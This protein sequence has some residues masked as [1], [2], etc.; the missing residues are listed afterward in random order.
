MFHVYESW[1]ERSK[2]ELL[3]GLFGM[4]GLRQFV[5]VEIP[6]NS[7]I[8][9]ADIAPVGTGGYWRRFVFSQFRHVI[10]FSMQE[11]V[12]IAS[13]SIQSRREDN[14]SYTINRLKEVHEIKATDGRVKNIFICLDG[15][16]VI[17]EA[18]DFAESE[19]Q[20]RK[21]IWSMKTI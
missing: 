14:G 4:P 6:L 16:E 10:E 12:E 11:K 5:F 21:C 17:D 2:S 7:M 19:L 3:Q 8:F 15:A 20:Q 1:E 18:D 13:L 9:H